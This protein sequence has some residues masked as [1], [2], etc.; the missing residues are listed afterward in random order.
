MCGISAIVSCSEQAVRNA[1][2]RMTRAMLHRGPDCAGRTD[3]GRECALGRRGAHPVV[4]YR[5]DGN[6]QPA[7]DMSARPAPCSRSTARSTITRS[8]ERNCARRGTVFAG[9]PTPRSC[10]TGWCDG[11]RTSCGGLPA[12]SR[13]DAR[14]PAQAD[15]AAGPRPVRDQAALFR[16]LLFATDRSQRSPR[17]KRHEHLRPRW[18]GRGLHP[19]LPMARCKSR[20]QSSRES[21]CFHAGATRRSGSSLKRSVRFPK[22]TAIGA[23]RRLDRCARA[24][25][26]KWFGKVS[27]AACENI[28]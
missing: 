24:R 20:N 26:L 28:W 1:L 10:S 23:S 12:C 9:H 18:I 15:I 17:S 2:P 25:Q 7:H 21:I 19:S 13:A 6:R 22:Q 4:N 27:T 14:G 8:F 11:G 5:P 16:D 3:S